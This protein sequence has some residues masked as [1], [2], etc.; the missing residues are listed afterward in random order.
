MRY[1]KTILLII[2]FSFS[3]N[4]FAQEVSYKE[5]LRLNGEN[6]A[7][8]SQNMSEAEVIEIMGSYTSEVP[9]GPIRNPW[10]TEQSGD[11]LILHYLVKRYPPFTP[12]LENQASP[13]I[14]VDGFVSAIGRSY[15][16]AAREATDITQPITE[17]E[18]NGSSVSERI[19]ILDDLLESGDIDQ[20]TYDR[21]KERILDSI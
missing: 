9:N 7:K 8:V 14:L 17:S 11:T 13:I 4:V 6:I 12:I 16:R 5:L 18:S 21:Q 1:I 3:A 10:K 19:Q 20:E 2:T 15:L